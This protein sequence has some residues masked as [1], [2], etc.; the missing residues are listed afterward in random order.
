M[1]ASEQGFVISGDYP[2]ACFKRLALGKRL[3]GRGTHVFLI[4]SLGIP[5]GMERCVI[6][7]VDFS[8][9]THMLFI[10]QVKLV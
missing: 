3:I 5:A 7:P 2:A 8:C 6:R 1:S 4:G 9:K 10:I